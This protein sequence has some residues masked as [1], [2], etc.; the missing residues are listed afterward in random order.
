MVSSGEGLAR[1]IELAGSAWPQLASLPLFVPSPRVA[2]QA[3]EAGAVDVRDCQ[4]AST[5]ALLARLADG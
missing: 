2:A 5:A 4:G 1:L 3:S